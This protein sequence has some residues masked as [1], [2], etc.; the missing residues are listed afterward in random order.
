MKYVAEINVMPREE[1]L[2]PQGKATILGLKNL[3]FENVDNL[4][5]GKRIHLELEAGSESE[6]REQVTKACE[7]LLA[8]LIMERYEFELSEAK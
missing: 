4:R 7:K 5:I 1:L 2:D 6:A 3:G 8:N